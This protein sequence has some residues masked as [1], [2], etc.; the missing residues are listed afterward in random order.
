LWHP[1][2]KKLFKAESQEIYRLSRILL[3]HGTGRKE[4]LRFN[5]AKHT[6]NRIING[7]SLSHFAFEKIK[8]MILAN[9]IDSRS[10]LS[11]GFFSEELELSRTPI[12]EAFIM[13]AQVGLLQHMEGSGF[14]IRQFTLKDIED[15]FEY[16]LIVET[17]LTD[18]LLSKVT[19][20]DI[21]SLKKIL[22]DVQILLNTKEYRMALVKGNDL[23]IKLIEICHNSLIMDS[24]RAC[25]DKIILIG[26]S[27]RNKEISEDSQREHK[28]IVS[29]LKSSNPSE[30]KKLIYEHVVRSKERILKILKEDSSKLYFVP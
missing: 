2:R 20:A 19:D 17:A 7:Q 18:L 9:K 23:H 24:L 16:R 13:L 4:S 11:E 3:S 29:A 25:Y 6:R 5:M 12:R 22:N 30:I 1:R 26:W 21:E 10:N 14:Y 28:Q 15:L 8:E 27:S